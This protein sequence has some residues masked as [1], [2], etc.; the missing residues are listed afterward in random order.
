MQRG[1][2]M[3]SSR[4]LLAF[5]LGAE[6]GRAILRRF[7]GQGID[8]EVV[9]RF[10]NGAVRTLDSMHWTCFGSTPRCWPACV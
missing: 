6:S 7:D 2:A 1:N 3:S 9:H 8:L 4:N 10:P 5:D